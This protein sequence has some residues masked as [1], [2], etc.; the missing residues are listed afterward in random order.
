MPY[1]TSSGTAENFVMLLPPKKKCSKTIF[2]C[3]NLYVLLDVLFYMS[4]MH[5]LSRARHKKETAMRGSTSSEFDGL[6][7]AD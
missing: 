6:A 3:P 1:F 5:Q 2:R 7:A 4:R